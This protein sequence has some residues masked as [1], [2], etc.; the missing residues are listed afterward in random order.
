MLRE[1]GRKGGK[2][3]RGGGRETDRQTDRQTGVLFVLQPPPALSSVSVSAR[4]PFS[5]LSSH[6]LRKIRKALCVL[7]CLSFGL[8][9]DRALVGRASEVQYCIS[10]REGGRRDARR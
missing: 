8:R 1:G 2:G 6:T 9:G 5:P 10:G 3:E 4:P 7:R